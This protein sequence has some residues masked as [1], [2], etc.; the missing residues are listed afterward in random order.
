MNLLV[1]ALAGFYTPSTLPQF[2]NEAEHV[3]IVHTHASPP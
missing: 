3:P 2:P 1:F